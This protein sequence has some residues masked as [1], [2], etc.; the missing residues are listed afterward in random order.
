[1]STNNEKGKRCIKK[2]KVVK[3]LIPLIIAI[4]KR[5]SRDTQA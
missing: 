3:N 2:K 5:K 1:M 4:N